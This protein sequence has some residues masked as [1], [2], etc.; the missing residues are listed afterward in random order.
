[1]FAEVSVVPRVN[2]EDG[3]N[4]LLDLR[5]AVVVQVEPGKQLL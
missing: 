5:V 1:M 3:V 2:E 4:L